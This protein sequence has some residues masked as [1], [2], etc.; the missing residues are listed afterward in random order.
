MHNLMVDVL[1]TAGLVVGG[2][3]L[4]TV[5]TLA[6]VAIVGSRLKRLQPHRP[7]PDLLAHSDA[8][9]PE[10]VRLAS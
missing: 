1:R 3:V 6:I 8:E 7:I 5:V 4:Y 2:L 10:E 9:S